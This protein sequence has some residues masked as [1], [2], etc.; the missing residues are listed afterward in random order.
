MISFSLF[1]FLSFCSRINHLPFFMISHS[2]P[3]QER[4]PVIPFIFRCS[5]LTR[6]FPWL[7]YPPR[8]WNQ[9]YFCL[10][11]LS[12]VSISLFFFSSFLLLLTFYSSSVLRCS[13]SRSSSFLR[14]DP[15]DWSAAIM[16]LRG[17][18]Y[19]PQQ[20]RLHSRLHVAFIGR[21][22]W[23]PDIYMFWQGNESFDVEIVEI[24]L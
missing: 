21:F 19:A 6:E 16:T 24:S 23:R 1:L 10:L 3:L 5:L 18:E 7:R 9:S 14:R 20:D 8:G 22:S 13:W 15:V 17:G 2:L 12:L 4:S 11:H